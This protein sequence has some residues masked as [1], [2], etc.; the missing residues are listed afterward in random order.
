MESWVV[1]IITAHLEMST[2]IHDLY[3]PLKLQKRSL[4]TW[5][6]QPV[7]IHPNDRSQ[8]SDMFPEIRRFWADEELRNTMLPLI[9]HLEGAR[10]PTA[11]KLLSATQVVWVDDNS[12]HWD[13]ISQVPYSV[14]SPF[15]SFTLTQPFGKIVTL[16]FPFNNPCYL[17]AFSWCIDPWVVLIF[18]FDISSPPISPIMFCPHW[19][20]FFTS[21]TILIRLPIWLSF[22]LEFIPYTAASLASPKCS[23]QMSWLSSE[24]ISTLHCLQTPW[25]D[26]QRQNPAHIY[27]ARFFSWNSF[28]PG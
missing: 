16:S 7:E 10:D 24:I 27:L 11:S 20:S 8:T 1:N 13:D 14:M 9:T 3:S 12:P 28:T 15:S 4:P 5:H 6:R 21:N 22:T 26:F 19:S 2:Y 17:E 18:F 23:W 25:P